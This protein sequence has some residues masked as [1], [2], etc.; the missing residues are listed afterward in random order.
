[1]NKKFSTLLA[2]LALL[3]AMN[4]NAGDPVT[5][6]K[7]TGNGLY[8]LKADDG[9]LAMTPN[10]ALRLEATTTSANLASTL[11]CVE[12]T[13]EGYGKAPIF[14]FT[15]KATGQRL[16][17]QYAGTL[18][19][20]LGGSTP[21]YTDTDSTR[22]GGEVSGW[23]YL[24]QYTSIPVAEQTGK[25]LYSYFKADSVIGL[26]AD[27]TNIQ[28]TKLAAAEAYADAATGSDLTMFSLVEADMIRLQAPEINTILGLQAADKGVAL[29]FTPDEQGEKVTVANP[30]NG[31]NAGKFLAEPT[32]G[33]DAADYVFVLTT[34]SSYLRV[35]T[36]IVN[37]SGE[38]FRAFKWSDLSYA[39]RQA[40]TAATK[41]TSAAD[42]ISK[43]TGLA[44]QYKFAF[45]YYP[46]KDSLVIQ[47]KSA[48]DYDPE[49]ATNGSN[50]VADADA[51]VLPTTAGGKGTNNFVTVQD[52]IENKVRIV[53]IY[54]KKETDINLGFKGCEA[55]YNGRTSIADGLYFIMNQKGQYLAS[56]IHKDGD[57]E[58]VTV[59]ADEQ[60]PAH[61]PAYQWV[62]LKKNTGDK[63]KDYSP[64]SVTNRE[65][66]TQ[67]TLSQLMQAEGAKYMTASDALYQSEDSL[68]FVQ[69]KE[70]E[71]VK[72]NAALIAEAYQDT[73]LG[74]KNI[75]DAKFFLDEYTF[76]YLHP[77]AT[78]ENSKYLAKGDGKDSL[79]NVLNGKDAFRLVEKKWA[80]FGYAGTTAELNRA[81]IK[82]LYRVS[83]SIQ[84]KDAFMGEAAEDKYAMSKYFGAPAD[85]FFFKENNHHE[86]ECFYAIV[87]AEDTEIGDYKAGVT[88]DILD[89]TVKVQPL[90]ETRTSAFAISPDNTP[91]YRR[92]NNVNLDESATDGRD[93]LRFFENVRKE[94]LMDE[95]N[96]DGGL[97]DENVNY[98]G[99][100]TADKATGLAFQ[101]DTAWVGRGRGYIKPQYLI[102][103]NHKDFEGVA[104]TPCTEGAPHI[105]PDGTL[106]DD[107]MECKHAHPA[108]PGFERA[109]Y[110]VSFQDSVALNGLDKPYADIAGGYTRVGFVEGIRI[111][112]TLWVL[113]AEYRSVANDKIDFKALAKA[114]ST[115]RADY[116]VGIKNLLSGDNHK[117]Y[118]WSFR[119]VHPENA[120]NVTAEG[121]ENSFL[122]ESNNYD[123]ENIAPE[124]AAWLKIQN[125]CVVLTKD[126]S[127]FANAKTGG[128]GALIFNVENKENDELATDNEVIATSEVTV[129]A[130]NGNIQIANAAGKKV[131]ITNILGQTV[132]N[133]V[134]TSSN[135]TIAAPAGVVVVAVEGE[136]A[137]KAIVK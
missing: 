94:Y 91:L 12:V 54:D 108:I 5:S 31:K 24:N 104:G 113:P 50:W 46:S 11:W 75:P 81:G 37:A 130:G 76:K 96:R 73:L 133:T 14:D 126:P 118:T 97:M 122:F 16:D 79:L 63:V 36:S 21:T 119:Y 62:V 71:G 55:G 9:V 84:L 61:M 4:A 87:K 103:V 105:K 80:T 7:K 6:L 26:V 137:V 93:S 112:D 127:L 65:Y 132:A 98:A 40:S 53:T 32:T 111:A 45:S 10:G 77:Y 44:D 58:W 125:G 3:G 18:L 102:S 25:T 48:M 110:L 19:E 64:V 99:M 88:D 33:G 86:G 69:V 131:V 39:K 89:A 2:G 20:G 136:E 124:N 74:Y 52:L 59:K 22:V 41:P 100:W 78:G 120:A 101:I 82:K 23:A 47:V 68:I 116:G 135:A 128:D 109:K 51:T 56:P 129:I 28:V 117:N 85:S 43:V 115:M 60:L 15:N 67:T 66:P 1:M 121:K 90:E 92:F 49:N 95:N 70:A 106:T 8:Q 34:D 38:R 114:D 57:L 42:S 107:P 35:D 83:Y 72:G 134:I 13:E 123:G 27:G 17:I 29:T 30:F